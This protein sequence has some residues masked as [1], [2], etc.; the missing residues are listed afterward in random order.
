MRN[1]LITLNN[2]FM[3]WNNVYVFGHIIASN[4]FISKLVQK[5]H[6]DFC[7]SLTTWIRIL[8]SRKQSL[9]IRIVMRL[10]KIHNTL[11]TGIIIWTSPSFSLI[12][13]TSLT[14]PSKISWGVQ[15]VLLV[16]TIRTTA[17]IF[18]L[19]SNSPFKILHK[20][21]STL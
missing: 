20:I 17:N 1:S 9:K 8:T 2:M 11:L 6:I 5:I 12:T 18:T 3:Y 15:S 13:S 21:F 19:K 16:P 7:I 10:I 4:I 14:M